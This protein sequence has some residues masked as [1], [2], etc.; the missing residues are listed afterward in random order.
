MTMSKEVVKNAWKTTLAVLLLIV[1]L[2][3]A[4]AVLQVTHLWDWMNPLTRTMMAW[5]A[6]A[7]HV[8]MYRTGRE[9]WRVVQ[10]QRR[11][12]QEREFELAV[13]AERMDEGERL[14]AAAQNE[15]ELERARLLAWEEQLDDRQAALERAEDEAL[16]LERLRDLYAAM[17]PQAAA[18]ILVDMQEAEIASLL[19]DMTP[20]QAGSILA[21]LPTDK[22]ANV[23]RALGL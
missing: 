1:S 9:E 20:R 23:S 16:A 19:N 15:L 2:M 7:P 3:T 14:L 8:E 18:A 4:M 22:A 13:R 21:A 10:T 6:L 5:P 12:L 11:A 17:R